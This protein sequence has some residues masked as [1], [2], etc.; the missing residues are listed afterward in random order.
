LVFSKT[1]N[2]ASEALY[3]SSGFEALTHHRAWTLALG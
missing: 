3:A 2:T 1:S